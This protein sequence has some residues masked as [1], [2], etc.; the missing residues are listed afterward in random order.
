[1]PQS[2]RAVLVAV[3]D[4]WISVARLDHLQIGLREACQT[5]SDAVDS[6]S[7]PHG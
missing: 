7:D 1:V 5:V 3:G 4:S 6:R 2:V